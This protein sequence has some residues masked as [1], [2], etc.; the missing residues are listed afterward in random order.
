MIARRLPVSLERSRSSPLAD[1]AEEIGGG[2][3]LPGGGGLPRPCDGAVQGAALPGIEIVAFVIDD[4]FQD[5]PV[6]K[7][8][9]VDQDQPTAFYFDPHA[10]L[11]YSEW[12]MILDRNTAGGAMRIAR[13][14]AGRDRWM[15]LKPDPPNAPWRGDDP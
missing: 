12:G 14:V 7:P 10:G 1:F 9:G 3:Q 11:L 5:G 6:R 13:G 2:A 4:E 15:Q 8:C